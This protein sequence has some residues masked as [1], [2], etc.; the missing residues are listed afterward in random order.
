LTTSRYSFRPGRKPAIDLGNSGELEVTFLGVGAAFATEAFQSN[1]FLVKGRTHLLVDLGTKAS[2]ALRDAGLS[3]LDVEHL[4]VTHSH[5]DHIGGLE[6]WCLKSRYVAPRIMGCRIG[7]YRPHLYTTPEYVRI[8]WKAS[9]RGGLELS[10]DSG[11]MSLEDYLTVH[12]ATPLE[13]YGRP[14]HAFGV[15]EG[16]DRIEVKLMRTRHIPTSTP[17]W[18]TGFWSVG[19]L[20]DDRVLISGDTTFDP[21]LLEEFGKGT[22]AIF[23]DCQ[24]GRGGVHAAYEEL[25]ALPDELRAKMILYHLPRGITDKFR[26]E[27]DGFVGWAKSFRQGSYLFP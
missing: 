22:E 21:E 8:L 9:L 17:G 26:P 15:G 19:L 12:L 23:H 5:A 7:D 11:P 18:E 10:E 20:V 2:L 16:A 6:E 1:I 14:V 13:G 27:D 4:L 25:L 3:V 24:D